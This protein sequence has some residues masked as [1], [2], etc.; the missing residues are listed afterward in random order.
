MGIFDTIILDPLL[1]C[2][3]CG[4]T[5]ESM[6]T[7]IFD[8]SMSTKTEKARHPVSGVASS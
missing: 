8:S 4:K 5:H 7:K 1:V 3:R 6:Q 2:P